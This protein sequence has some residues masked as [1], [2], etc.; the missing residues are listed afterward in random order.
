MYEGGGWQHEAQW[1]FFPLNALQD[2]PMIIPRRPA[3]P[4]DPGSWAWPGSW[5]GHGAILADPLCHANPL[6]PS[7]LCLS[8][9]PFFKEERV[10]F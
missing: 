10:I 2:A 3:E 1:R 8:Y 9:L 7:I 4:F 5:A 6:K